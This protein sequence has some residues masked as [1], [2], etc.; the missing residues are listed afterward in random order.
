[1]HQAHCEVSGK[2]V[3][4]GTGFTLR[5]R[6]D[7][8][9]RLEDGTFSIIDYKSGSN[10]STKQARSLSPQLALEAAMAARGAFAIGAPA[11]ASELLYVRLRPG[12]AFKIDAVHSAEQPADALAEE[13]HRRLVE[14]IQQYGL[15]TQGYVSKYAPMK[16][17]DFSGEY[18]HLARV[19][20]WAT[21][22]SEGEDE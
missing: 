12:D 19:R 15:E 3:V 4:E 18:D 21:E 9:D 16:E 11:A 7:R 5:G 13:S 8:I 14:L 1:M 17:A 10:P 20:E 2:L 22:G 6:A